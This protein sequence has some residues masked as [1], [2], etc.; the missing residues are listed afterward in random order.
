MR[1]QLNLLMRGPLERWLRTR[2]TRFQIDRWPVFVDS[3][4]VD[5]QHCANRLA[6]A[7]AYVTQRAPRHATRIER[8]FEAF[9]IRSAEF[10]EYWPAGR[11]CVVDSALLQNHPVLV[12][13]GVLVHENVQAA[14]QRV[15]R[16]AAH[17]IAGTTLQIGAMLAGTNPPS[18]SSFLLGFVPGVNARSAFKQA[19]A[20]CLP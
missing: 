3:S 15:G 8:A 16:S 19:V 7:L 20:A 1:C 12:V 6:E 5:P 11:A 18:A 14:L 4:V 2:P 9:L 13:G 10:S 17:G